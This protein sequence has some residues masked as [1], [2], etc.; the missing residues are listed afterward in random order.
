MF[1]I[2]QSSNSFIK[3]EVISWR[4]DE[5]QIKSFNNIGYNKIQ[6]LENQLVYRIPLIPANND[7][8]VNAIN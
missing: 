6:L 1:C 3:S 4:I 8:I 7:A 5:G 2:L